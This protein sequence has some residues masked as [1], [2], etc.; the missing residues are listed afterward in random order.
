MTSAGGRGSFVH[1][2]ALPAA[3]QASY[4]SSSADGNGP[5]GKLDQTF[6]EE[7][8]M[9]KSKPMTKE[10]VARIQ[11]SQAEKNGG[12]TPKGGWV[13]RVQSVVDKREK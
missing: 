6:L 7:N 8:E 4:Q 11:R 12:V 2:E 9:G 5:T 10:D 13:P 1:S 3:R